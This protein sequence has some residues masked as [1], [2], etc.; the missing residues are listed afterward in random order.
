MRTLLS[1]VDLVP[2]SCSRSRPHLL[3]EGTRTKKLPTSN[4][5]P[6]QFFADP[7]PVSSNGGIPQ[8]TRMCVSQAIPTQICKLR[9]AWR[10]K[11]KSWHRRLLIAL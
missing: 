11:D 8:E 6:Q 2:A 3:I 10:D 7:S 1:V 9:G 4:L 5:C